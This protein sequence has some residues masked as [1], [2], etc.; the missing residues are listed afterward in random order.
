MLQNSPAA[1]NRKRKKERNNPTFQSHLAMNLE[2]QVPLP[3]AEQSKR[4]MLLLEL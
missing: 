1:K 3:C 2:I 4:G